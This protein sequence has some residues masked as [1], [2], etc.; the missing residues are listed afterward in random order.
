MQGLCEVLTGWP[1][2]MRGADTPQEKVSCGQHRLCEDCA[3][4]ILPTLSVLGTLTCA[5]AALQ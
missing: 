2:G 3:A 4:P 5:S 1:V